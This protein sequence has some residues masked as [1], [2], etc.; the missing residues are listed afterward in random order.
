MSK[1]P[2]LLLRIN[3][4]MTSDTAIKTKIPTASPMT[5][6][7]EMVFTDALGRDDDAN[8]GV[9]E[10]SIRVTEGIPLIT[11]EWLGSVCKRVSVGTGIDEMVMASPV[12]LSTIWEVLG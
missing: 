2:C 6:G 5:A 11:P 3:M 4:K 12:G 1:R 9:D 8:E 7:V 10:V